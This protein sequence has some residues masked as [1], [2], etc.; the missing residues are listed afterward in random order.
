MMR[1]KLVAAALRCHNWVHRR[2]SA[3]PSVRIESRAPSR[4]A[5]AG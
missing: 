5:A 1:A 2:A 4:Q 3:K